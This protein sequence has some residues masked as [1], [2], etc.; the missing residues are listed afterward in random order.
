VSEFPECLRR[1]GLAAGESLNGQVCHRIYEHGGDCLFDR[2]PEFEPVRRP[3]NFRTENTVSSKLI[4]SW[5]D[6]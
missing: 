1:R 5:K 2:P 6:E 3:T 4:R